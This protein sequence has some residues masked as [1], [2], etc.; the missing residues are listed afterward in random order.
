MRPESS[1]P[2]IFVTNVVKHFKWEPRGKR[3]LHAKP[4]SQ[5]IAACR[6]WLDA[7][8][9]L[10]RPRVIVWLGATPQPRLA[11]SRLPY[12]P[13][14]GEVIR[15][16]LGNVVATYHP[17]AVLRAP[18]TDVIADEAQSHRRSARRSPAQWTEHALRTAMM[19]PF[20]NSPTGPRCRPVRPSSWP[21]KAS[22]GACDRG[23]TQPDCDA[24]F[25]PFRSKYGVMRRARQPAYQNVGALS[26]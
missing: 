1:G 22:R 16:P 9:E 5:E 25:R 13:A 24:R 23:R 6:A 15:G 2:T 17:S 7:E 19:R 4:N 8:L 26:A 3:R 11:R 21:D 12:Y 18:D 14:A 10:V 20:A